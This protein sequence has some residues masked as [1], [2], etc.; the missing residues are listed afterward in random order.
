MKY[1]T[2]IVILNFKTYIEATGENAVNL[3]RTCE[4]VADETGVNIVVA[5]QHMDLFRVAQTVK[6][7]VAAQ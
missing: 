7:P 3:A 4:Q 2:P 6:I 5:P 1:D